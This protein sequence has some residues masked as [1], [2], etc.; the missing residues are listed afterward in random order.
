MEICWRLMYLYVESLHL[1]RKLRPSLAEM[2][3]DENTCLKWVPGISCISIMYQAMNHNLGLFPW[4]QGQMIFFFPPK[5]YSNFTK[6]YLLERTGFYLE[7]KTLETFFFPPK[8]KPCHLH[9]QLHEE[10]HISQGDAFKS[11]S[12]TEAFSTLWVLKKFWRNTK[13]SHS[14]S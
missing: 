3:L 13:H 12:L 5:K 4:V 7:I 1:C 11:C 9:S 10:I 6:A 8:K 2:V 14:D